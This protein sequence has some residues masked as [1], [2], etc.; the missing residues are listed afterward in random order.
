MAQ[1]VVNIAPVPDATNETGPIPE[2]TVRIDVEDG[3]VLVRELTIR[4][5]E[6]AGLATAE[7]PYVDFELL[8]KAFARPAAPTPAPAPANVEAAAEAEA[9]STKPKEKL[10]TPRVARKA[11]APGKRPARAESG[12]S[13]GPGRVYRRA[14]EPEVLMAAYEQTGS[15][16]GVAAQFGVPAHTAQGWISRLRQKAATQEPGS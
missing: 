9:T 11:T 5:P 7:P 8:L 10:A 4:A 13:L 6:G 15:I 3:Q 2:A 16:A 1:Y 14:P 12:R